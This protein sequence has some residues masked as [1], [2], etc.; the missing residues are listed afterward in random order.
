[1]YII[2]TMAYGKK[3]NGKSQ[4]I[5]AGKMII[6]LIYLSTINGH[7]RNIKL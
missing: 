5:K 2:F 4:L 6:K 3:T 1:M 7:D